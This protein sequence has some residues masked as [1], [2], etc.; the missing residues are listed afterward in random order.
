MMT[1]RL[2]QGDD[3]VVFLNWGYEEDPPMGLPLDPSDEPNRYS[4][5]LYHLTATQADISGKKVLE[6]SCGHGGG[7]SYLTRTLKPASYTGLDFNA[8]G[9]EFCRKRHNLPGLDFVHGDAENLPFGDESFDAVINVEASHIYPHFE[10]FLGQ[11]RRVLRPGGHFLYADFRNRDGF[12]AWESALAE[13]GLRQVS[14]RVIN[15]EVLRGLQ[16]NSPR[17]NELINRRLPAFLRRFGR[18]FAVVDGSMF[19]RDLERNEI[20][21]RAYCFIKD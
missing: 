4:I 7:A 18:E 15:P 2:R 9:I 5:Q 12:D 17:S 6:V 10:R 11:V 8:A 20:D 21:Y 19:Y 14:K 13:S 3:D 1:R 16:K